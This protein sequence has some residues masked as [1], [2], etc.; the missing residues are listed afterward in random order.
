MTSQV[1]LVILLAAAGIALSGQRLWIVSE[2]QRIR[3]DGE[4]VLADRIE[5]RREVISPAVARNA[6]TTFRVVVEAPPDQP[7][8]I[9]VA[10]NPDDVVRVALYQEVYAK[11][12]SEWVPDVVKP[13]TLPVAA[14]LAKGQK[15]QSYLLDLWVPGTAPVARFRLEVQFNANGRW[16][17]YPLEIRVREAM[18]PTRIESA[19][20]PRDYACGPPSAPRPQPGLTRASGFIARNIAQDLALARVR[21]SAEPRQQIIAAIV[22]AG[23]WTTA[24]EFCASSEPAPRGVEWWLRARDYLLQ[25]VPVP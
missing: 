11:Q 22:R 13:V 24:S 17:I 10:Q 16:V 15:I 4:T 14:T 12:G 21:E 3:P 20:A 1:R 8:Y 5:R 18:V 7:Y 2:Y 6:W 23:G 19:A 25:G 9:H